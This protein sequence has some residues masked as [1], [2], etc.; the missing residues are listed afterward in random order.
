MDKYLSGEEADGTRTY[1]LPNGSRIVTDKNCKVL[2]VTETVNGTE[3]FVDLSEY[4]F[5]GA[6]LKL[7]EGVSLN[8]TNGIMTLTAR[9]IEQD[10]TSKGETIVQTTAEVSLGGISASWIRKMIADGQFRIL[11]E[12]RELAGQIEET[13]ADGAVQTF[14]SYTITEHVV[15][16]LEQMNTSG[17]KTYYWLKGFNPTSSAAS[18]STAMNSDAVY[19]LVIDSASDTLSVYSAEKI[20]QKEADIQSSKLID[21]NVPGRYI[22]FARIAVRLSGREFDSNLNSYQNGT[23]EFLSSEPVRLTV[24]NVFGIEGIN[25]VYNSG[26]KTW[27]ITNAN[28]STAVTVVVDATTGINRITAVE[29]SSVLGGANVSN[30]YFSYKVSEQDVKTKVNYHCFNINEDTTWSYKGVAQVE[31]TLKQYTLDT[32]ESLYAD[33][34]TNQKVSLNLSQ[35][36]DESE[37]ELKDQ[38]GNN[39]YIEVDSVDANGQPTTETVKA[40][41]IVRTP[42][43]KADGSAVYNITFAD[44]DADDKEAEP[45]LNISTE[46]QSLDVNLRETTLPNSTQKGYRINNGLYAY[47]GGKPVVRI[48]SGN[49]AADYDGTKFDSNFIT[50]KNVAV[51]ES[52][53]FELT[54]KQGAQVRLEKVTDD[55]ARTVLAYGTNAETLKKAYYYKTAA[56]WAL[57][58]VN[59]AETITDSK[60][61][62]VLGEG[63]TAQVLTVSNG[64]TPLVSIL[65]NQNGS[66]YWIRYGASANVVVGSDG[67]VNVIGTPTTKQHVCRTPAN[68]YKLGAAE[69]KEVRIHLE[70]ANSTL[71][72]TGSG[73]KANL[74]KIYSENSTLGETDRPITIAPYTEGEKAQLVFMGISGEETLSSESY[75]SVQGNGIIKSTTINGGKLIYSATGNV[76]FEEIKLTNGAVLDLNALGN[77]TGKLLKAYISTEAGGFGDTAA[78]IQAAGTIQITTADFDD[79]SSNLTAGGNITLGTLNVQDGESLT[80]TST[81]GAITVTGAAAIKSIADMKAK[82]DIAFNTLNA[83]GAAITAQSTAGGIKVGNQAELTKTTAKLTAS[84]NIEFGSTLNAQSSTLIAESENGSIKAAGATTLTETDTN[85]TANGEIALNATLTTNKGSLTAKSE[86]SG[87]KVEK[88]V[89][90]TETDTNLTANGE[91]ALNNTLTT[92]KGSLTAKSENGGIKVEK[93]VTL[94]DTIT[95]LTAN[96]EILLNNTL[97]ANKGSLKVKTE[98]GDMRIAGD[99]KADAITFDAQIAGDLNLGG[100]LN[101]TDS[102]ILWTVGGDTALNGVVTLA[103]CTFDLSGEGGLNLANTELHNGSFSAQVKDDIEFAIIEA[104]GNSVKL[105]SREGEIQTTEANGYIRYRKAED[106]RLT[107]SAN[108]NIGRENRP[109]IVDT[110][111]TLYITHADDYFIDSVELV[112]AGMYQGRRPT[113]ETD[114][115]ITRQGETVSGEKAGSVEGEAIYEPLI[116]QTAQEIAEMLAERIERGEVLQLMN[117]QVLKQLIANGSIS[118]NTLNKFLPKKTVKNLLK[119]NSDEAYEQLAEM[120]MPMADG[121]QTDKQGNPLVNDETLIAWFASAIPEVDQAALRESIGTHLTD[122]EIAQM[123][124]EA[125]KRL[126]YASR[127]NTRPEEQRRAVEIDVGEST[128]AAYVNNEGDITVIQHS[129]TLTVGEI[130]SDKGNVTL[131]SESG[132][133]EGTAGRTNITA[134]DITLTAA[135]GVGAKQKLTIDQRERDLVLTAKLRQPVDR[136]VYMLDENGQP[137]LQDAEKKEWALRFDYDYEWLWITKSAQAMHLNVRAGGDVNIEETDGDMGLGV[138]TATGGVHLEATDNITDTRTDAQTEPNLT[139]GGDA[140]L[141]AK[142]G[143][144][145]SPDARIITDVDGTIIADAKGDI[146]IGDIQTLDLIAQSK[147]G[148]VNASAKENLNLSNRSGDLIVGPIQAGKDA[149]VT[150]QGSIVAGDRLGEDAQVKANSIVL[151]A[152]NGD[153]GTPQEAFRVDTDSENGGT[154]SAN[155]SYLNLLELTDDLILKKI[156][157]QGDAVITAPESILDGNDTPIDQAAQAQKQADNA[158]AQAESA[159]ADAYVRREEANMADSAAEEIRNRLDLLN[160]NPKATEEQKA[161]LQ[162]QLNEAEQK[163]AEAEANAKAAEEEAQRKQQ[164]YE[165]AQKNADS[166]KQNALDGETTVSAGG[167]LTLNALGDIGS[168][169]HGLSLKVQG[170]VDANTQND[171][172]LSAKGDLTLKDAVTGGDITLNTLDGDIRSNGTVKG[173]TLDANAIFGDVDLNTQVDSL[174]A[175]GENVTIHNNGDV[176][177]GQ[178]TAQDKLHLDVNG[179]V[180]ADSAVKPNIMAQDATLNADKNIGSKDNPVDTVIGNLHG[181]GRKIY[182]ENH[183]ENLDINDVNAKTLDVKT[184]GNVTG[185]DITVRDITIH[186]NGNVGTRTEPLTF[187]ASGRVDIRAGLLLNYRNL[188]RAP[189]QGTPIHCLMVLKFDLGENALYVLIGMD[190]NGKLNIMGVFLGERETDEA[191]WTEVFTILSR[192]PNA[193]RIEWICFR[194]INGLTEA[195]R[196]FYETPIN[197]CDLTD[198]EEIPKAERIAQVLESYVSDARP[199]LEAIDLF[200]GDFAEGLETFVNLDAECAEF[201]KEYIKNDAVWNEST[202]AELTPQRIGESA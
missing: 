119:Q 138:I 145:G 196:K 28:T 125:Q 68:I 46:T 54:M 51:A 144:V 95:T 164:A 110:D 86:N 105:V 182:I 150:A 15:T 41:S 13:G 12:T 114:T 143:T 158:K 112:G 61:T 146:S 188:Y 38:E 18:W 140:S 186:A 173:D 101:G 9:E 141:N 149:T 24:N 87:I 57:A 117:T 17:D 147:E 26:D 97:T 107:L 153:I 94:T 190:A 60:V 155:G 39:I 187:K 122:E 88:E 139:A 130:D 69:G 166:A 55:V 42:V 43:T 178:I 40:T 129:G 115:G 64:S 163:R 197:L 50:I 184:Q 19:Y 79:C 136:T 102:Q 151:N 201:L 159:K 36:F 92:N 34:A 106:K 121:T 85:L 156:T 183:S 30:F 2:Y 66:R 189:E 23:T 31:V 3:V 45:V 200:R 162:Q 179:N 81:N 137:T 185:R 27:S 5:D 199:V 161:L 181:S 10:G 172:H 108:G 74:A 80:L 32:F 175:K 48:I 90:L 99:T 127:E 35:A 62:S 22:E 131:E 104:R 7:A 192:N 53:N 83:N 177:I 58:N 109:I 198:M 193:E 111:D 160:Q 124:I 20:A 73:I 6:T 152:K 154:L 59:T 93:E 63:N 14:D 77:V 4:S 76:D 11:Y 89:S 103:N 98:N 174:S 84:E 71:V 113:V 72:Q 142:N 56:G 100:V 128:G 33:D 120:L 91:I 116:R 170:E 148:Q 67:S 29:D 167:N 1:E 202:K 118:R 21:S 176:T 49:Y 126:D 65:E 47:N 25:M 82:N 135:L 180:N 191:F 123:A 8:V 165:A 157:A 169:N 96:G 194:D 132:A 70:G 168:D 171:L 44:M 195:A 75:V 52:A 16:E 133:I 78:K 37:E 134:E